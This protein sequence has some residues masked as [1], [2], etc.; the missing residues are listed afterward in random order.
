MLMLI[1]MEHEPRPPIQDFNQAAQRVLDTAAANGTLDPS[2]GETRPQPVGGERPVV[3]NRVRLNP[4]EAAGPAPDPAEGIAW[5]TDP[6]DDFW[7]VQHGPD[8]PGIR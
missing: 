6:T 8:I 2:P 3:A 7:G 4:A 1:V 5:Q